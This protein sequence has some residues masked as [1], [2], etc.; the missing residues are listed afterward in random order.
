MF[1]GA[2]EPRRRLNVAAAVVRHLLTDPHLPD[3]L[4]PATW[5]APRLRELYGSYQRELGRLVTEER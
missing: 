1:A 2:Q 5:P 4:T 3:E